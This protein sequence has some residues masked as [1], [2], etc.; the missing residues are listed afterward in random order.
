LPHHISL[1]SV[2]RLNRNWIVP[3]VFDELEEEQY[4][5][6][7]QAQGHPKHVPGFHVQGDEAA[8]GKWDALME[9]IP[10]ESHNGN[11][12]TDYDELDDMFETYS[13]YP[14]GIMP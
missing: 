14:Y 7:Q 12:I 13:V 3:D 5:L 6:L 8:A 9:K 11:Y 2:S 4:E 10:Q 1:S